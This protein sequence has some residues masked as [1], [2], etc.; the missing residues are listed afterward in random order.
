MPSLRPPIRRPKRSSP[1]RQWPPRTKRSPSAI[2][3]STA[4]ISDRAMSAVSSVTTSGVLVTW[5]PRLFAAATSIASTPMP[6]HA[7]ISTRGNA[8]ISAAGQ[9]CRA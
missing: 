6:K 8:S 5:I 9:P 1:F 7:M 2:R 3:R 4:S